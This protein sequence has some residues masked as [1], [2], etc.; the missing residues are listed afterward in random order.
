[1]E[2]EMRSRNSPTLNLKVNTHDNETCHFDILDGLDLVS[3]CERDDIS[4]EPGS[5][6]CS[7]VH[8]SVLDDSSVFRAPLAQVRHLDYHLPPE[9]DVLTARK[10]NGK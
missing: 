10:R 2:S 5:D 9:P 3:S 4:G 1:M 6:E 8:C 7:S